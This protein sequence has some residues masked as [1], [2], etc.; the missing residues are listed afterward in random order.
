MPYS[1]A[2]LLAE[3]F[4]PQLVHGGGHVLDRLLH[5]LGVTLHQRLRDPTPAMLEAR[6]RRTIDIRTRN[7]FPKRKTPIHLVLTAS[8]LV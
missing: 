5:V 8:C 6:G 1:H 2:V 4:D 3:L 7:T